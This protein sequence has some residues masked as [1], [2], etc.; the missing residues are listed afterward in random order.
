MK[1]TST[2]S[3]F[4]IIEIL[5]VVLVIGILVGIVVVS[6]NAVQTRAQDQQI[7]ALLKDAAEKTRVSLSYDKVVP[8]ASAISS[9][10]A[11]TITMQIT[12]NVF[13]QTF[14]ITAYGAKYTTYSVDEKGAMI[15]APCDGHSGGPNY[16]PETSYVTL[17]GYYCSGTLGSLAT[18]HTGAT[19]LLA[20]DAQVPTGAPAYYVGRQ[21]TRDNLGS[22]FT[23]AGGDIYCVTG[24]ATT[25]S[26][27]VTH[28][29]GIRFVG[30]YGTSFLGSSVTAASG[31]TG[32]K[33]VTGCYTAPANT[34]S[35]SLWTQNN[36]A[37]GSTADVAW[38]QTAIT[39][40]K[41]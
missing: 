21:N 32:W 31:A 40:K 11:P 13:A 39:L 20:T 7:Q 33:K 27:T 8:T 16:C 36:G 3:G 22:S 18:L 14:C 23:A 34:T 1:K 24:W 2:P 29:F 9:P 6:Y 30:S 35:A 37:N 5:I 26:S 12:G 15:K 25:I 41:Q 38:F 10:T 4:T 19:K 28:G 17:N